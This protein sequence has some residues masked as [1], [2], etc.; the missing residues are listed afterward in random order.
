MGFVSKTRLTKSTSPKYFEGAPDLA[1]EVVSPSDGA[2]AIHERVFD[3]LHAGT[4][5]VWVIYPASRTVAVHGSDTSPSLLDQD[6]I[7]TWGDVLPGLTLPVR[8]IF[9]KLRD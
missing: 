1:V 3:F 5:L 4:R 7:L 2:D 6:G 8:D 9:K